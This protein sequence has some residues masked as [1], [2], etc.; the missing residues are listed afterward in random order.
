MLQTELV[1]VLPLCTLPAALIVL[2]RPPS[3]VIMSGM[4]SASATRSVLGGGDP[5]GRSTG[6]AVLGALLLAAVFSGFVWV[7]KGVPALYLREPWQDDP[8]DALVSFELVALPLLVG[9]CAVR[10][11]SRR[12][13]PQRLARRE[14]DLLR[15]GRVLVA[16]VALTVVS[17][18]VS[19]VKGDHRSDWDGVT[20]ALLVVLG[21]L[22][23]VTFLTGWWVGRALSTVQRN[24]P[25]EAQPDWLADLTGLAVAGAA[26]LGP[27]QASALQAVRLADRLVGASVRRHPLAAAAACAVLLACVADAP[28]VVLERYRVDFAAYFV[29][30][31]ACGLFAYLAV[32]GAHVRFVQ[33]EG[34]R[35]LL[36]YVAVT[37]CAGV[38]V[39]AA[40]R[41]SL[42][43][44]VGTDSRHAGLRALLLLTAVV[45][46]ATTVPVAGAVWVARRRARDRLPDT[47]TSQA[48][49]L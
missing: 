34:R 6:R 47:G 40:F 31:T 22:T 44:L 43:W 30:V 19:V 33:P 36:A 13:D 32:V 1:Q 39:A 42:W 12:L 10:L 49:R 20:L 16:L 3:S 14:L 8:Y 18:W 35:R 29:G 15:A 2:R 9:L 37:G 23:A 48:Y 4:E 21:C 45:V 41:D 7:A 25:V 28:Q 24:G 46:V 26:R 5:H 17:E 27:G 38:G 11:L